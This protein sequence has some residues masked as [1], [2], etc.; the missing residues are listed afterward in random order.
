MSRIEAWQ[1][2]A[3]LAALHVLVAG[4]MT[5]MIIIGGDSP[6]TVANRVA[7]GLVSLP[8]AGVLAWFGVAVFALA[9]YG[10]IGIA[11]YGLGDAVQNKDFPGGW[12]VGL[13]FV[14]CA[15]W[16]VQPIAAVLHWREAT[17][18]EVLEL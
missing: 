10:P 18:P 4:P 9:L 6:A 5:A 11:F 3:W 15:F 7:Y 8:F 12:W 14:G 16:P 2:H 13:A 17:A 1:V